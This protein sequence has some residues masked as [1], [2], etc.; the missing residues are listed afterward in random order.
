MQ[1]KRKPLFWI[2][3]LSPVEAR[4]GHAATDSDILRLKSEE[5]SVDINRTKSGDRDR[6][7]RRKSLVSSPKNQIKA[8]LNFMSLTTGG[9]K[10]KKKK[11]EKEKD[12]ENGEGLAKSGSFSTGRSGRRKSLEKQK[13]YGEIHERSEEASDIVLEGWIFKFNPS[14]L[15]KGWYRKWFVLLRNMQLIRYEHQNA[16]SGKA[17]DL[18]THTLQRSTAGNYDK[19]PPHPYCFEMLSARGK[20][21][22]LAAS[23]FKEAERW[24]KEILKLQTSIVGGSREAAMAREQALRTMSN[25]GLSQERMNKSHS[26]DRGSIDELDASA[27]AIVEGTTASGDAA[28]EATPA[29]PPPAATKLNIARTSSWDEDL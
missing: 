22:A 24:T 3:P 26:E 21:T 12:E 11:K 23:S 15:R 1:E 6:K 14:A 19:A 9:T 10:E 20:T 17:L 18:Y 27:D 25:L 28:A 8:L 7:S 16:K 13:S 2:C 4:I 29:S 5:V